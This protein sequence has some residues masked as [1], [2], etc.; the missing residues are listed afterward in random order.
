MAETLKERMAKRRADNPYANQIFASQNRGKVAE[1]NQQISEGDQ[2]ATVSA[3]GPGMVVLFKP[4]PYGHM[5][6]EVPVTNLDLVLPAGYLPECPDCGTVTCQQDGK[7][8]VALP[9]APYRICPIPTCRKVFYDRPPVNQVQVEED[10]NMIRDDAYIPSTPELR[11]KAA[12]DAHMQVYHP[13]EQSA[14][15]RQNPVYLK[16]VEE[17]VK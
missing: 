11:T 2:Q 13:S 14:M 12:L 1:Y 17:E 3:R 8:C 9:P 10:E 4:G 7:P 15:A 5:R 16:R 6:V